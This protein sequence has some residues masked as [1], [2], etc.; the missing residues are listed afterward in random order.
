MFYNN[1]RS[2]KIIK[3]MGE[4][5]LLTGL[6]NRNSYQ[7]RILEYPKKYTESIACIYADA[8]G[9]HELNNS[10]GHEAGD[11]MLQCV[12]RLLQD[13]FGAADT[14]RIGGDEFVAFDLDRPK[15]QILDKIKGIDKELERR[16][17]HIS[18]GV[19]WEE[20]ITSMDDLVR[21]AEQLMYGA[22][23]SYYEQ[24]GRDRR[25]RN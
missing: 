5:D 13:N 4:N 8:N 9:L 21:E 16:G 2:F 3:E 7:K 10:Q 25:A 18:V 15:E 1:M 24:M 11:R 20:K 19:H 12:A 23:R 17:Y 6:L 22:K 14:Y